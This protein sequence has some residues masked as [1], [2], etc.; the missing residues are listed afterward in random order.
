MEVLVAWRFRPGLSKIEALV[1]GL[2]LSVCHCLEMA[3]RAASADFG[4]SSGGMEG[5]EFSGNV[6]GEAASVDAMMD[7]GSPKDWARDTASQ[8]RRQER[9]D[10]ER[11]KGAKVNLNN[12]RK[13]RKKKNG[14]R[15]ERERLCFFQIKDTLVCYITISMPEHRTSSFRCAKYRILLL[16][17]SSIWKRRGRS[18]APANHRPF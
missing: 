13:K 3:G 16:M 6:E 11:E 2:G 15:R 4:R 17:T 9:E 7:F 12:S 1:V 14:R 5:F 8:C 10:E 18:L